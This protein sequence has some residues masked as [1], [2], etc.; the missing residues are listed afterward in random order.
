MIKP[1]ALGSNPENMAQAVFV[2][3]VSES[4]VWKHYE[5][6]SAEAGETVVPLVLMLQRWDGM[7][8]FVG[9][10]VEAG[11]TLKEAVSRECLEEI[12]LTLTEAEIAAARL[13]SSHQTKSR[14]THLM[15]VEVSPERMVEAVKGAAGAKHFM[16]ET[17]AVMPVHF[18]NYSHKKAFD[19]FIKNNFASTVKEEIADLINAL[20]WSEKYGLPVDFVPVGM[21]QKGL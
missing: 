21:T 15:T 18:I 11:E 1:I 2:A 12:D 17:V 13:V 3:L 19:N 16:S 14:V 6:I 5:G 9:G 4:K 10:E 8:G 7:K 20:G